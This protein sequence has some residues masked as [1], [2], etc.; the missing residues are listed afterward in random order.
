MSTSQVITK[1][2]RLD[3]QESELLARLSKLEGVS[4]AALMKRFVL[5]GIARYRLERAVLAY[6][7]GEADLSATARYAGVSVYRMMTELESRDITPPATAQKFREGLQTLI[8][9]FGGSEAL[10]Q[11]ILDFETMTQ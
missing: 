5:D 9:T 7:Q 2:I 10:R 11:T 1:S 3:P 6:Q 4:E 8:D